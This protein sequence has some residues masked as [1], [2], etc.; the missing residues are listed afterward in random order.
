MAIH[1]VKN[2]ESLQLAGKAL[3]DISFAVLG[4]RLEA[5]F[6]NQK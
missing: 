4:Y 3:V 1:D 5:E 2:P 6:E